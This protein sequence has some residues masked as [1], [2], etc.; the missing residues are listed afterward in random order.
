MGCVLCWL[1]R[2]LIYC[3]RLVKQDRRLFLGFGLPPVNPSLGNDS[4]PCSHSQYP[5][6]LLLTRILPAPVRRRWQP[7]HS[8][9]PQRCLPRQREPLLLP[10]G[11]GIQ[12]QDQ[13]ADPPHP[14]PT[15]ALH[16]KNRHHAR[17]AGGLQALGRP[18]GAA[19]PRASARGPARSRLDA[20]RGAA[21][22]R[23]AV[24]AASRGV[25]QPWWWEAAREGGLSR[26]RASARPASRAS[27]GVRG[28]WNAM[29]ALSSRPFCSCD[30]Q[31]VSLWYLSAGYRYTT[32]S[33]RK[34]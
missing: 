22:P 16:A 14:G 9:A 24:A 23:A 20:A 13:L 28:R 34:G 11:I 7:H 17:H 33:T 6:R 4:Q 31:R 2:L 30:S 26:R 21:L 10:G 8:L 32:Y 19:A 15:P 12:R 5:R 1:T 18:P 27:T 29:R 25:S 3:T